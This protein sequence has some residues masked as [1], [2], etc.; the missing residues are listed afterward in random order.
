MPN[1]I[2]DLINHFL[3]WIVQFIT[4]IDCLDVIRRV[5]SVADNVELVLVLLDYLVQL[6]GA[7]LYRFLIG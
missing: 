5:R 4:T 1:L 2:I 7:Y 6:G 3:V